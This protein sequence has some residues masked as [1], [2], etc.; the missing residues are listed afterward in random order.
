LCDIFIDADPSNLTIISDIADAM[1]HYKG[2]S[3]IT[4]PASDILIAE[5][6][7]FD[8]YQDMLIEVGTVMRKWKLQMKKIKNKEIIYS[9]K[10]FI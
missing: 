10:E 5:M 8:K 2:K 6:K 4:V 7:S 1:S 9:E 3:G